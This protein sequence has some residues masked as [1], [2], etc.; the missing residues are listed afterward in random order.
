MLEIISGEKSSAQVSR[1]YG[2]KNTLLSHWKQKILTKA[3]Q[4]FEQPKESLS[5]KSSKEG[6]YH[7]IVW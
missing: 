2:I 1:E 5:K 6:K 4:L 7:A 3:S